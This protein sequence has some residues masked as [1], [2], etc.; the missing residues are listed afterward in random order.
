MG[1][2]VEIMRI[3]VLYVQITFKY[4]NTNGDNKEVRN[5]SIVFLTYFIYRVWVWVYMSSLNGN[6]ISYHVSK[7][8]SGRLSTLLCSSSKCSY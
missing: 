7:F 2:D 6:W 1:T 4:N 3:F 5:L 8:Q